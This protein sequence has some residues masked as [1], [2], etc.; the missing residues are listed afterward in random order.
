MPLDHRPGRA[1]RRHGRWSSCWPRMTCCCSGCF[2]W[3]LAPRC[4]WRRAWRCC[5]PPPAGPGLPPGRLARALRH[6][7]GAGPAVGA[8]AGADR[9]AGAGGAALCHRH[10]LGS[11]RAAFPRAVAVSADG[12]L[13]GA[14]L[15]GDAFNLF[16][17]FE[18][19]LIASYGLMVHGGGRDGCAPGVQ[20]VAYNL[21]GSTLFLFALATI[22]SV[23]GTLNMADLA[24]KLPLLP[25]GDFCA[26]PGGR[27]AADA[28]LCG[29]G[30]AGAAAFL[31]AR[32]L[33]RSARAGGGAVCDHD[34]G[35]RLCD[36]PLLSRWSFRP[37]GAPA[38]CSPTCCCPAALV[39]LAIGAIGI[40]GARSWG[41]WRPLRPSPRWARC[42]P[43][44]RNYPAG[45]GGG[46]VLYRAF[47]AGGGAAVPD[48]RSGDRR[49]AAR[50]LAPAA[51]DHARNGCS[52][53]CSSWPPPSPCRHAAAVG[54]PWQAADPAGH[55]PHGASSGR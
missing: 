9:G 8:D 5:W 13:N 4:W 29:Q 52:R 25:Q 23:T 33:C 2:R 20:Y 46:A 36:H 31:A 24:V 12:H 30:R 41:G 53:R 54:L 47:H 42:S 16:V 32:H 14:F 3:P 11:A 49:G 34:Q 45:H 1:A 48:R 18:V 19:L 44:C 37:I 39:T 10:R 51:P 27:G 50:H 15:T 17:F 22:Y 43:R 21:V 40:L 6:R 55:P 26:D 35:R 38:R 28:G 7:A